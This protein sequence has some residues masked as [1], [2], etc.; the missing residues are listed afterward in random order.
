MQKSLQRRESKNKTKT[1]Y[2]F[3]KRRS[4]NKTHHL[5]VHA[6]YISHFIGYQI[7]YLNFQSAV[8]DEGFLRMNLLSLGL[9]SGRIE[10]RMRISDKLN[11]NTISR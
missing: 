10:K 1:P 8:G 11:A 4:I 6:K 9:Y 3:I 2:E 7:C 5:V